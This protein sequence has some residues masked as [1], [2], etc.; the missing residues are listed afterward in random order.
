MKPKHRALFLALL[1]LLLISLLGTVVWAQ[2]SA[3]FNLEWHVIGSGGQASNSTNY[4]LNGTIGQSAASPPSASS[5]RFALSSG[6]WYAGTETIIYLP[7]VIK[8]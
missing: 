8:Q 3:G 7:A 2:T 5:E 1:F 4:R 6:Y